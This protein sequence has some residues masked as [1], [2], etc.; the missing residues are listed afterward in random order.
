[1]KCP[2]CG[3]EQ[4]GVEKCDECGVYYEKYHRQQDIGLDDFP[5]A[6]RIKRRSARNSRGLGVPIL[7][8]I[9]LV[10]PA[11][12]LIFSTK[13]ERHDPAVNEIDALLKPADPIPA[14]QKIEV[15]KDSVRVKLEKS[16]PPR[17]PIEAARNATV[18]IETDW[19]AQG[20]GFIIDK[21]CTVVTNKHVIEFDGDEQLAAIL[22]SPE[23]QN[24]VVQEQYAMMQRLA[25]LKTIYVERVNIEGQN[26]ETEKLQK[27]ILALQN[28][29]QELPARYAKEIKQEVDERAVDASFAEYKIYLFDASE[30]IVYDIETSEFHDLAFFQLSAKDCPF[31]EFGDPETLVQG[32]SLYTIGNPSGLSYTVT[33]GIFSGFRPDGDKMFLQTDAPINPGNSGGPL[34]TEE[35]SVVGVNTFVLRE[36]QNIGFAIPISVVK[37]ELN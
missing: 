3:A 27:E 1:M 19:G 2:A 9:L 36:A 23:L 20:S 21:N 7:L 28:E 25:D 29:I 4:G 30:Y 14:K 35:G 17:N 18:F 31:I 24:K 32:D 16:H 12:F 15:V 6:R 11:Y 10:V 22:D 33:S 26:A 34:I 8:L 37:E 13:E 5:R